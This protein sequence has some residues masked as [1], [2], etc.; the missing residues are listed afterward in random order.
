M[1]SLLIVI[2]LCGGVVGA[3]PAEEILSSYKRLE[4]QFV[5]LANERL[6]SSLNEDPILKESFLTVDSSNY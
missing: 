4:N 5:S 6:L 2:L 3:T 1:Y